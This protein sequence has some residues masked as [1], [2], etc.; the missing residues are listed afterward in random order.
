MSDRTQQRLI[1]LVAAVILL[2]FGFS[3]PAAAQPVHSVGE[4]AAIPEGSTGSLLR[5]SGGPYF[6]GA[7]ANLPRDSI[8]RGRAEAPR[9]LKDAGVVCQITNA[10]YIATATSSDTTGKPEPADLFEV[11]CKEGLGYLII[12]SKNRPPLAV[13]CIAAANSGKVACMLPENSQAAQGLTPFLKTAGVNCHPIRARLIAQDATLKLRR[14]EV[15]CGEGGYILDIPLPDGTGAAPVAVDCLQVADLCKFTP[16]IDSVALLAHK[17][18]Q[19]LGSDC[20]VSDARYVGYVQARQS[21]LYEVS[22]QIGHDGLLLELDRAGE[23]VGATPC[24]T[25][26]LK[27]ATCQ[28]KPSDVVDPLIAH[29][30]NSGASPALTLTQPDWAARPSASDIAD[31]YPSAAASGLISGQVTLHC[32]TT[33]S[34]RLAECFVTDES[35]LGFGFGEAAIKMA[36]RFRMKPATENG[37]PVG[38]QRVTIPM[39]FG[40][41]R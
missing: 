5:F 28:L 32:R 24:H 3:S 35:P 13:D 36:E 23:I 41:R 19:K 15:D 33:V 18:G 34:G 8:L 9:L 2:I 12:R 14:Y 26:K 10:A 20:R 37:V 40:I 39:T 11:S 29:A 1:H 16:H 27:G 7:A 21:D 4:P 38:G 17:V 31:L 6:R 25:S 30:Q 22:C